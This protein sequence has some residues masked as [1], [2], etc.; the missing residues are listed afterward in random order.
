MFPYLL[1]G[2]F[3]L[4]VLTGVGGYFKGRM[5]EQEGWVKV[6]AEQN[7]ELDN[8]KRVSEERDKRNEVAAAKLR[9]ELVATKKQLE[10]ERGQWAKAIDNWADYLAAE[11]VRGAASG[12]T[13][14]ERA[15][16]ACR[17][18]RDA[19]KAGLEQVLAAGKEARAVTD[20]AYSRLES[21][22]KW[23]NGVSR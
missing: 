10:T 6:V 13:D 9:S 17:T 5:D 11:R 12:E 14:A 18:E 7:V 4:S 19:A 2:A 21:L 8:Y 20:E 1:I 22:L 23:A 15:L 3:V 16:S